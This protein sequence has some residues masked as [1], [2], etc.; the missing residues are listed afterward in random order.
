[1]RAKHFLSIFIITMA[2]G[3]PTYVFAKSGYVRPP[4]PITESRPILS[5]CGT[6]RYHDPETNEC[7]GPGDFWN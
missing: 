2:L 7:R 1:M 3:V 4:P 6:H 5:E